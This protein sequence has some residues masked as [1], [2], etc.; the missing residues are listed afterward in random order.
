[1]PRRSDNEPLTT[2]PTRLERKKALNTQ[3]YRRR[4]PSCRLTTGRMV[5]TDRLS[6]ATRVTVI[7]RPAVSWRTPGA[8]N[9]STW[10]FSVTWTSLAGR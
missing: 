4:S 9:P 1:M 7:A 10:A 6:N 5:A 2:M 3:P 8:H